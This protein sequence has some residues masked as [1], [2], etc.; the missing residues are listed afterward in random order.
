MIRLNWKFN[1]AHVWL[2]DLPDWQYEA[3]KVAERRQEA[4]NMKTS[5]RRY[6]ALELFLPIGGRIHY[7]AL[8]AEFVPEQQEQLVIQVLISTSEGEPVSASLAEKVDVVRA[9]LPQE[10]AQ[11]ILENAMMVDEN[12]LLGTGTLRFCRAVHGRDGSS[13][14]IFGVL[15]RVIVKL[16]ILDRQSSSEERLL[17]LIRSEHKYDRI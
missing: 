4:Q 3:T 17:E 12:Q 8:G 9:G 2:D 6:A 5:A 16:L 14:W 1:E 7:G 13:P 10:F 15:T 11:A